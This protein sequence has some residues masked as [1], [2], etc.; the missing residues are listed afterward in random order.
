MTPGSKT[1]R[2]ATV[3]TIAGALLLGA[4]TSAQ[5]QPDPQARGKAPVQSFTALSSVLKLGDEVIVF[6]M[7][8]RT[9]KGMVTGLS[10]SSL[11]LVVGGRKEQLEAPV[12][13]R[14]MR[15]ERD[16]IADGARMGF[17]AGA[18]FGLVAQ[19]IT[20]SGRNAECPGSGWVSGPVVWG[21]VAAGMGAGIDAAIRDTSVI[22]E[23]GSASCSVRIAPVLSP[24]TKA[25]QVA[26]RWGR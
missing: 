19:V 13:Q 6:G 14:I 1:R 21:A 22:Y 12:I 24:R 25:V 18:G 15:D 8:G 3:A 5:A 11:L 16:P 20:C 4:V 2:V 17:L 10:P 7:D 9:Y 23:R 26:V